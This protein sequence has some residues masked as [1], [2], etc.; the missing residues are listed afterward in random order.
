M[1]T[2]KFK[3][4]NLLGLDFYVDWIDETGE[5]LS[6][7]EV[8]SGKIFVY[9]GLKNADGVLVEQLFR[10]SVGAYKPESQKEEKVKEKEPEIEEET[11]VEEEK[12]EVAP[13][14]LETEQPKEELDVKKGKGRSRKSKE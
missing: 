5:F 12:V 9:R 14:A 3:R 2:R 10:D 6:I 13:A 11:P 4:I 1:V 8:H 7:K